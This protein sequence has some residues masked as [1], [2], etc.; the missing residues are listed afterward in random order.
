MDPPQ[1]Y[2]AARP[3]VGR[4]TDPRALAV[5]AIPAGVTFA[6]GQ[7]SAFAGFADAADVDVVAV[8]SEVPDREQMTYRGADYALEK[9]VVDGCPVDLMHFSVAKFNEWCELVEAGGGWR[10]ETWPLPLHVVGGFAAGVVLA[11]DTEELQARLR[12]PSSQ[13]VASVLDSLNAEL[14]GYC[15]E[16]RA[17]ARRGDHWLFG[18]LT[19]R[20]IRH[21][22]FAWFAKEGHYCPF[23]K[24]VDEWILHLELN[25]QVAE[26]HAAVWRTTDL[27]ERAIA[28][29]R[30]AVAVSSGDGW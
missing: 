22:Y 8:W 29:E 20:L 13:Y 26:L 5:Q 21:T 23:P 25:P 16:L 2:G 10:E 9:L 7:G 4:T 24:H 14:R 27:A 17:C 19:D 18:R 11:G 28:I 15:E 3:H 12:R 30:F 6:Y 1:P